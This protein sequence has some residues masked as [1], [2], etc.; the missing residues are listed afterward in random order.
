[1]KIY[2]YLLESNLKLFD[3]CYF[4]IIYYYFGSGLIRKN[5]INV[6]AVAATQPGEPE[7]TKTIIHIS[8]QVATY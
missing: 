1:M 2:I 4:I 3:Y 5:N 6:M 7:K 8:K